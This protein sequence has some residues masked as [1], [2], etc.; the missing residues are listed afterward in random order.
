MDFFDEMHPIEEN[1]FLNELL[2]VKQNKFKTIKIIL[3]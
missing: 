2:N 3:Y 1:F